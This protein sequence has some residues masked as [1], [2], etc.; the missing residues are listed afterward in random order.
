MTIRR[1]IGELRKAYRDLFKA[2]P[3]P[4]GPS[5]AHKYLAGGKDPHTF[6]RLRLLEKQA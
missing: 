3:P 5:L 6:W 4:I 2:A 1:H